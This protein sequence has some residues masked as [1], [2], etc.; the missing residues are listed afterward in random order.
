MGLFH[1]LNEVECKITGRPL[2]GERARLD[3]HSRA[4][5]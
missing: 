3:H 4:N 1:V 2:V 5:F